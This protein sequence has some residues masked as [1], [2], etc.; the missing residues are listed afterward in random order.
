MDSEVISKCTKYISSSDSE[1][2]HEKINVWKEK[3]KYIYQAS[4]I[5][6]SSEI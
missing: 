2:S 4:D 5:K 1:F 3:D 6:R